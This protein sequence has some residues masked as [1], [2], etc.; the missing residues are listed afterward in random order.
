MQFHT[1][2]LSRT[3]H[4][5]LLTP[6]AARRCQTRQIDWID[7]ASTL[8]QPWL[9]FPT[10]YGRRHLVNKHGLHLIVREEATTLVI[11]TAY[12]KISA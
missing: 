5:V 1:F 2:S 6:H 3:I 10:Y 12:W 11:L 8:R 7:I 9:A 4:S